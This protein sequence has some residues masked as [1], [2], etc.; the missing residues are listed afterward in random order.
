[1]IFLKDPPA[2]RKALSNL[3]GGKRLDM[4]VAFIG[5]DW[6]DILADYRGKL[7]A[8]CWLS[9]TNTNPYAVDSLRKRPLTVVK[10]RDTMHC[11]VYLA[12][13]IGAVV[14]SANLSKA[15]LEESDT[16]GQDEAAIFVSKGSTLGEIHKWFRAMWNDKA[17]TKTIRKSHI[18]GAKVAFDK[19]RAARQK[20][21]IGPKRRQKRQPILPPIPRNFKATITRCADEVRS[22][23][24]RR[25]I[26]E[27]VRKVGALRPE[28]LTGGQ[29]DSLID[30]IVSW[31][32]HPGSYNTFRNVPISNVRK[33]LR[34]LFDESL[35]LQPRLEMLLRKKYLFGLRMQ[36]LS[37]LLYWRY[38]E[39]YPPY[40]HRTKVFL[41]DFRMLA[42]G[43]S[44]SSPRTYATWLRW[45]TRLHQVLNLPTVGHVDRL[46][47]R[48]Y[49]EE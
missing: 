48:Y 24:L 28:G 6:E 16:A 5:A 15:A 31:T 25:D 20:S 14:G 38:P 32:G 3:L 7:R 33:G 37:L 43:M 12:P 22:L 26:A 1:M 4:A 42:K 39:R 47:Q 46:V 11:K 30:L 35:E 10:Q 8:I 41:D 17:L 29:R 36:T 23:N 49:D 9:S 2:I 13:A 19:A 27:P 40:N 45:A 34:L 44:A 21:G 18:Y